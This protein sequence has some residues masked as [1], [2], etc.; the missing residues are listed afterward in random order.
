MRPEEF[1]GRAGEEVAAEVLRRRS[2]RAARTARRRHRSARRPASPAD[3]LLHRVDRAGEVAGVVQRDQPRAR[4]SAASRGRPPRPA[5]CRVSNG[6]KRTVSPRS[7]ASCSQGETLPSWSMRVTTISSPGSKR[8]AERARHLVGERRH[9]G[10]D[11]HLLGRRGAEEI[12][13][14]LMRVVDHRLRGDRRLEEA[15]EI[16]V[17]LEQALRHGVG[18]R[19]RHLRAGGIV[20]IDAPP[21]LVG[22][23]E[24]RKLARTAS[25]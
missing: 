14:R 1:V 3:Q 19:P 16:G 9:V 13:H 18:H 12:G 4:R 6:R 7:S 22:D 11:D 25:I 2:A 17:G 8:A 10:A 21:A 15:A 20:E 5:S 24:R 23:A